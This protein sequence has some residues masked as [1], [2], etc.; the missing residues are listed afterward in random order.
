[1]DFFIYLEIFLFV[2]EELLIVGDFNIYVDIFNDVD[3]IKFFD[4]FDFVGL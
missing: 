4:L 3:V 1:M 2:K